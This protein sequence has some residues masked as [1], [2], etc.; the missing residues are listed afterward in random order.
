MYGIRVALHTCSFRSVSSDKDVILE[1]L[2]FCSLHADSTVFRDKN[3]YNC[4]FA[5]F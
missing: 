3:F 4:Y 1:I 5:S 2:I